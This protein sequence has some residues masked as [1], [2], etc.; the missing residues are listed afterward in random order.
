VRERMD[1]GVREVWK[2]EAAWKAVHLGDA[3]GACE[4]GVQPSA[5]LNVL[6]LPYC[7]WCSREWGVTWK[8]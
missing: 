3:G 7:L 5:W 8:G 2:E 1:G 6:I 4:Q